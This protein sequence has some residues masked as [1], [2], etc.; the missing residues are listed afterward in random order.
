MTINM[1]EH[2][3]RK[4]RASKNRRK[5]KIRYTTG[6]LNKLIDSVCHPL[7]D[8]DKRFFLL[9]GFLHA[10]VERD[11]ITSVTKFAKYNVPKLV[12]QLADAP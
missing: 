8:S 7:F 2:N 6:E 10:L 9:D 12:K 1:R 11:P 4:K 3:E 5:K